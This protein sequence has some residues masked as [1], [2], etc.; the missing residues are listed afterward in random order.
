MTRG[1]FFICLI[2]GALI[3]LGSV[4][5]EVDNRLIDAV[6]LL[7]N[8][9]YAKT[10]T[11]LNTL[12]R[13]EPDNDAIYYYLGLSEIGLR[14]FDRAE[15]HLRKAVELDGKNYWY[16]LFYLRRAYIANPLYKTYSAAYMILVLLYCFADNLHLFFAVILPALPAQNAAR[17][18]RVPFVLIIA[19]AM[20]E[21]QA[22]YRL[23][24]E[25]F[26]C[27]FQSKEKHIITS[28]RYIVRNLQNKRRFTQ[29]SDSTQDIQTSIQS[30]V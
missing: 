20:L 22:A 21:G 26:F 18:F 6:T 29:R 30:T 25:L 27:H 23:C 5:Q 9:D 10:R 17:A 7:E 3:P 14:D 11:I 8:G 12:L 28:A 2:I 19:G 16:R 24:N 13:T 1:K 15:E 4:A